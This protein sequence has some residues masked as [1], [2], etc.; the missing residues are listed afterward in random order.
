MVRPSLSIQEAAEKMRALKVGSLLVFD[1]RRLN[2]MITDRD[3][4]IRGTAE[5]RD[6]KTTLVS[7]CLSSEL[8]YG[9]EDQDLQEA[10]TLMEKKE[11]SHLP[12]L[13]HDK[14]MVGVVTLADL[15]K[16]AKA[17]TANFPQTISSWGWGSY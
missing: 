10:Q 9:F 6:P 3:I 16:A 5:G 14:K 8:I 2:G 1:G 13:N 7:D 12:V 15:R 17:Q 11:I 4:A